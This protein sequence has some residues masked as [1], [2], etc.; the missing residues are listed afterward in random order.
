MTEEFTQYIGMAIDEPLRIGRI[1]KT[2]NQVSLLQKYRYTEE[3]AYELCQK[4]EML[5]PI[6]NFAPR[7]GLLVLP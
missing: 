3:M 1:V 4:Y 7:G 2:K 5:S 6:Y